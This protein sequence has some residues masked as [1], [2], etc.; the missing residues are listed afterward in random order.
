M[1]P[2]HVYP[3]K[4]HR[5]YEAAIRLADVD[6]DDDAAFHSARTAFRN[7][8]NAYAD[9]KVRLTIKMCPGFVASV[10]K[11]KAARADPRQA[12]LFGNTMHGTVQT[13]GI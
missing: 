5:L 3:T 2:G 8:V 12:D 11:P 9:R 13:R 10:R 7:A 6:S 4:W 1:N